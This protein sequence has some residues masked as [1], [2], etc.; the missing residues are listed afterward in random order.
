MKQYFI[1]LCLLATVLYGQEVQSD[2]LLD[3]LSP[4]PVIPTD[5]VSKLV[6]D[7]KPK[8][9]EEQSKQINGYMNE[10]LKNYDDILNNIDQQNNSK[11]YE[12]QDS[13]LDNQIKLTEEQSKEVDSYINEALKNYDDIIKK[14]AD[15]ANNS[16]ANNNDVN[17]SAKNKQSLEQIQKEIIRQ[18]LLEQ[19]K[20]NESVRKLLLEQLKK[21]E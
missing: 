18:K 16:N 7:I 20:D 10:A 15:N 19:L 1:I 4:E 14:N 12:Q 11:N 5:E 3:I 21:L 17:N 6:E 8:L 13:K 9:N 2:E